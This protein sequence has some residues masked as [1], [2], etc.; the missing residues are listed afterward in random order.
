MRRSGEATE[1]VRES[2][3]RRRGSLFRIV[4]A[5]GAIPNEV[6]PEGGGGG[7]FIQKEE[8]FITFLPPSFPTLLPRASLA[9]RRPRGARSSPNG[10]GL[11]ER[12]TSVKEYEGVI[13]ERRD[14]RGC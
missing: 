2:R 5:R 7:E 12:P 3:R 6:R 9:V 11:G 4:H 8:E 1:G 13:T 14:R 10:V